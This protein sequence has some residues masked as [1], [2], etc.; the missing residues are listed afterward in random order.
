MDQT[1]LSGDFCHSDD[2]SLDG[3]LSYDLPYSKM[4]CEVFLSADTNSNCS[5]SHF[6]GVHQGK[7]YLNLLFLELIKS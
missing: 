7:N 1:Q 5:M 2:N 4:N 6:Y 3:P